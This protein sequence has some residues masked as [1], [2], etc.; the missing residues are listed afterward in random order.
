MSR[1]GDLLDSYRSFWRREVAEHRARVTCRRQ[2]GRR[3][4][5]DCAALLASKYGAKKV[6]LIGS[7]ATGGTCHECPDMDLVVEGLP[8]RQYLSAVDALHRIV[9]PGWTIDV[10]PW[11]D[12]FPPLREACQKGELLYEKPPEDSGSRNR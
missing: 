7:L 9:P 5:A 6:V 2:E 1:S 12:A 4:A 11:E 8:P 10:I 3:L